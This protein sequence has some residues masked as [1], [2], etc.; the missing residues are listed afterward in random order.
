[1][2]RLVKIAVTLRHMYC[3]LDIRRSPMSHLR[4][5]V[6]VLSLARTAAPSIA[7]PTNSPVK[8]T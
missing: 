3:L 8:R 7:P 1:M 6:A 4:R 2:A 5:V